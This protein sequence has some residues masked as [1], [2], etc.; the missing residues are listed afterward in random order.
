M[1]FRSVNLLADM[2]VQPVTLQST[3]VGAS[4]STDTA[5][6]TVSVAT[7]TANATVPAMSPV[8]VSG[9]ASD[10]GGG[11]VA[12]VEVSVDNGTTWLPATGLGS[13]SYSWTP[14]QTGSFTIM[15]RA[16][17]D[18]DN[19]GGTV[20]IPVTVGPQSCP[21]SI[22]P[23]SAT[24][25]KPDSGDASSV[26]LGVKFSTSESGAI[27]GVRFY[28]TS[29]NTGTH[30]GSLW[31][32]NGTLLGSVTFSNETASGW[33][34]ASFAQPIPVSANTTYVV[35]YLAPGGHYSADAN[36]FANQGAGLVPI[37][38]LQSNSTSANGVYKYG[39]GTVFPN[40]AYNNT[41]YY[42]DAV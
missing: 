18:S 25:A 9:T 11:V 7:P 28:K 32:A 15:V 4:Q 31:T 3:L 39:T 40:S 1:L 34:T 35:S 2:G 37:T 38:A 20:S 19:A 33:Q 5:G 24:P 23:N 6:P 21:C 41:N 29:T 22:F 27:T 12:R 13:W 26:N 30:T 10:A 36:Y 16:E 14:T 17:D 42:V 8:T